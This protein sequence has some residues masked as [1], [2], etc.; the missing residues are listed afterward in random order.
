MKNERRFILRTVFSQRHFER[1]ERA[2]YQTER[3]LKN[4]RKKTNRVI[5]RE[6]E[7]KKRNASSNG[8]ALSVPLFSLG[9]LSFFRSHPPF[10]LVLPTDS[11]M[12]DSGS[13]VVDSLSLN[14]SVPFFCRSS[15]LVRFALAL[16]L[17]VH[18]SLNKN[19]SQKE[20]P[21]IFLER[22]LLWCFLV[23]CLSNDA[24]SSRAFNMK[25]EQISLVDSDCCCSAIPTQI[26]T[27]ECRGSTTATSFATFC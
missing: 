14:H 19:G 20:P 10:W 8:V 17:C 18:G 4:G 1:K 22:S 25:N 11:F 23:V 9:F 3:E 12:Y 26:C 27:S 2:Q 21:L 16:V 24:D 6:S 15:T 5:E 13:V 7:R